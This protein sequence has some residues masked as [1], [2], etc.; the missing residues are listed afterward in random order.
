VTTAQGT[1]RR[2][3]KKATTRK[4][5]ADAALRLF[6]ERGYE[7]VTVREVAEEA[8]VSATTLLNYFPTKESLIFDRDTD[9]ETS[10]VRAVVERPAGATPLDALRAHLRDRVA[11][12]SSTGDGPRFRRLVQSAKPLLDYER[13]MWLRHLDALAAALAGAS[14]LPADD[15]GC[16]LVAAYA[17]QT[18]TL[19][20]GADN[21]GG[22]VDLGFDVIE[23]G[24]PTGG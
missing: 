10:L 24:W 5:I 21:P 14:E 3:R 23:H 19:A 12:D 16:R 17:L 18:L 2:E 13:A 4:A 20:F 9:I 8:D 6:L 11:R 15:H 1:G 7:G 22:I